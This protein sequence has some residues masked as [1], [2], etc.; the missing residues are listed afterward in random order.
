MLRGLDYELEIYV[1]NQTVAAPPF[2]IEI[3]SIQYEI[4]T[5]PKLYDKSFHI[6]LSMYILPILVRLLMLSS[7]SFLTQCSAL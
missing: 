2:I 7:S 4:S 1:R 3:E 5:K 6:F